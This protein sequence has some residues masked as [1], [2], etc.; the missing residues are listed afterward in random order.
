MQLRP[1]GD[2]LHQAIHFYHLPLVDLWGVRGSLVHRASCRGILCGGIVTPAS[3]RE[4]S[5]CAFWCGGPG[6]ILPETQRS[7][8]A[9]LS[10]NPDHL[11]ILPFLEQYWEL[12]KCIIIP[13]CEQPWDLHHSCSAEARKITTWQHRYI[14]TGIIPQQLSSAWSCLVWYYKVPLFSLIQLIWPSEAHANTG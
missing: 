8:L 11:K 14:R 4:G 1:Y 6:G 5:A 12:I 3:G 7:Q 13:G 9:M 10:L 2:S